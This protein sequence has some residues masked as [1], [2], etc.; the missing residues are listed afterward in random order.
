MDVFIA[1][2]RSD[3]ARIAQ[4]A[5]AV[6]SAGYS[7]WWDV[8]LPPH[9][10]YGDVITE[11]IGGAKAA[12]VVWSAAAAASE[13]VRAE[14][15]L[16]RNQRKLIQASLD[17]RMPPIPFNQIQF[18][19]IGDWDGAPDHPGWR[20]IRRSLDELCGA[21]A[22]VHGPLAM[23]SP[24]MA[25]G[26]IRVGWIALAVGVAAGLAVAFLGIGRDE[27][28]ETTT[29]PVATAAPVPQVRSEPPLR[30]TREAISPDAR[31]NLTA[32]I[33]DPDGYT[34]VRAGPSTRDPIIG[35][36]EEGETFETFSQT[37][38]WWEV[39][40]AEGTIGWMARSRI[41]VVEG[42]RR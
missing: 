18:A 6:T 13:W 25:A 24:T 2:A 42:E 29:P 3:Q 8:E 41:R 4:L 22:Q 1:Y 14:A 9:R 15:D 34:N 33:D 5:S 39:R 23:T 27:H 12:I 30:P 31:F 17:D 10:S 36:V 28:R 21:R 35:R 11:Q 7:V 40:T 19:S 16:A 20:K 26:G 38:S 32:M 37:G